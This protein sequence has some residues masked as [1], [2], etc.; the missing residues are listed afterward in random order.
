[1]TKNELHAGQQ[2]PDDA[3]LLA[4]E[5]KYCSFG[6]TVHYVEHPNLFAQCEN[7]GM[8]NIMD[9]MLNIPIFSLI[10]KG[11]TCM[12]PPENLTWISRCGIRRSTSVMETND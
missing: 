9:S 6:D 5:A 8:F 10:A 3:Q 7:I 1:M 4:D 11:V 12:T 2:V